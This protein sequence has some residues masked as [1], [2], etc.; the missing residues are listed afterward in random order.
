MWTVSN[1]RMEQLKMTVMRGAT[2]RQT[3]PDIAS[4]VYRPSFMW[5]V[6][7][8]DDVRFQE[9]PPLPPEAYRETETMLSLLQYV[10]GITPYV[11]GSS[12]TAQ[13]VDQNT[14]TGVSLLTESAS[15]P[16]AVQGAADP[17][18]HLAADVRALGG[19]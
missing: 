15:P 6:G 13:G 17:R 18:P 10:T 3:A 9:P 4:Y 19:A 14:A 5:V 12:G 1:L 8:H 2:V 16:L 11:S 7:D